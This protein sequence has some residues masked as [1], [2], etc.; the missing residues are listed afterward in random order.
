MKKVIKFLSLAI[1]IVWLTGCAKI[2]SL[3]T[4]DCLVTY[5]KTDPEK[6]QVFATADAGREYVIIGTVMVNADAADDATISVNLLK[7]RA[8]RIGADGIINLRLEFSY[9]YWLTAIK[10]SG[11]AIK[12][13]N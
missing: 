10:A 2:G 7:K 8:A 6:V 5:D 4:N 1:L 11:T 12:Y 13:I 9:G 3:Q